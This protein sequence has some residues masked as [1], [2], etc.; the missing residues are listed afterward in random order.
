LLAI[1]E[2]ASP[3]KYS[4][5]MPH[6]LLDLSRLISSAGRA[7][8]TG[9]DRV[10]LAYARELLSRPNDNVTFAAMNNLRAFGLVT[11][12]QAQ[13]FISALTAQWFAGKGS[14]RAARIA[15]R[16]GG[17]IAVRGE[18]V[19]HGRLRRQ[20]QPVIYL[21]VSHHH[22]DR[23][24]SIERLKKRVNVH[25]VPLVHDLIPIAFPEY[26][27]PNQAEIH[28]RRIATV[29]R[30]S[31]AVIVNSQA[32][33]DLLAP[34]MARVGRTV[35]ILASHLGL[36][37]PEETTPVPLGIPH[38]YFICIGTI[39]PRKNH[40]LLLKLWRRLAGEFGDK[41]PHLVIVGRRG[42]EIENVVDM[43][44]RCPG[45]PGK[46]HEFSEITDSEVCGMIQGARA[47]L[48]PSFSEGF[49]LPLMEAL[50]LGTP[51]L[52]S[53]IPAFLEVGAGAPE[54]F[55][56]LDGPSWYGAIR[57]YADRVSPR[58]DAQLARI[59]KWIAPSWQRHFQDVDAMLNNLAGN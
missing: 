50:A 3:G 49:G 56:P 5:H 39:E 46:V 13:A 30:L 27:R 17:T 24:A 21:N 58:R 35:P 23:P 2:S 18:R 43:L 54:F 1:A 9:I 59:E 10:E 40:L 45:L 36:D 55:D 53:D 7:A 42:W 48:F 26:Q 8:P 4:E 34:E 41:A 32:T 12:P 47:L 29:T 25:F 28:A 52:C 14:A 15:G 57:D 33:A 22:L 11:R 44:E 31:D 19:L 37:L 16:I 6:L 38:P 51:V 20:T